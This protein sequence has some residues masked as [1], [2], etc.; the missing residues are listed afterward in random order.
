MSKN[1]PFYMIGIAFLMI[2]TGCVS[3]FIINLREDQSNVLSRMSDVSN[4]FEEFSTDVSIYEEQRDLLY[5][6]VLSNLFYDNMFN[7]DK[8]VKNKISNYEAIV[9]EIDKKRIAMDELCKDVYYPD[10]TAN[11]KCSNYKSIYEQVINYFDHDIEYYNS[12]I[13]H[14]NDYSIKNGLN[15]SLKK[16]ESKKKY[17]DYNGDGKFD[18]KEEQI[19]FLKR[20]LRKGKNGLKR[21]K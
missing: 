19:C 20:K 9:D 8:I 13:N 21:K 18:G 3:A 5:T 2:F 17:I 12:N 11:S 1:L 6:D 16:Y 10:H 4:T 15:V 14:Q 7:T